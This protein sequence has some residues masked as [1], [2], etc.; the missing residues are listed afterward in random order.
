M[1]CPE[2]ESPLVWGCVEAA[3]EVDAQHQGAASIGAAADAACHEGRAL[4]IG[5]VHSCIAAA[6]VWWRSQECREMGSQGAAAR[7][8][9]VLAS[10]PKSASAALGCGSCVFSTVLHDLN[11]ALSLAE[12]SS[13]LCRTRIVI[14]CMGS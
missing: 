10:L 12:A 7:L 13:F 8:G 5:A 11:T 1:E 3:W 4:R 9:A 2:L 14:G 6:A